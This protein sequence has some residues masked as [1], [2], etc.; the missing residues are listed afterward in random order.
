META[1]TNYKESECYA[2]LSAAFPHIVKIIDVLWGSKEC[3]QY[4]LK[5]ILDTRDGSRAGFPYSAF[6]D[7]G[8]LIVIHDELFPKYAPEGEKWVR[9]NFK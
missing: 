8:Q 1:T 4:L 2:S 9:C 6:K 5:L 7:I 3:Q